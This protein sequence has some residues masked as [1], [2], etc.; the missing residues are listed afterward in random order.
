[1]A[2]PQSH[3]HTTGFLPIER[4]WIDNLI[5]NGYIDIY[6]HFNPGKTGA[7]T[8]WSNRPGVRARNIGWRIDYFFISPEF[9]PRVKSTGLI[10]E[11]FGLDPCPVVLEL[12]D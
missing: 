2:N 11:L 10:P 6:R 12:F 8:W 4:A 1:L 3:Q 7:Y 5:S 9:L